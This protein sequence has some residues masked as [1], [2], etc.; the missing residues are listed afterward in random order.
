MTGCEGKFNDGKN[1]KS[2]LR[3]R[4]KSKEMMEDYI[5]PYNKDMLASG[6]PLKTI[7]SGTKDAFNTDKKKR[8]RGQSKENP[9][10]RRKGL[11]SAK[12][13]NLRT[14][15]RSRSKSSR[16]RSK[17]GRKRVEISI[18]DFGNQNTNQSKPR[19]RSKSQARKVRTTAGRR[20]GRGG[21]KSRSK[22]RGK[23]TGPLTQV[24]I[25]DF[26]VTH[27]S[28]SPSKKS[29]RG[30]HNHTSFCEKT[31]FKKE[32]NSQKKKRLFGPGS[33]IVN[34]LLDADSRSKE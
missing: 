28:K 34:P 27:N 25:S 7:I 2:R 21:S 30:H 19:S 5:S 15:S 26:N 20:A 4:S 16:S 24:N 6:L 11:T 12:G 29:K 8:K 1:G 23:N 3:G 32:S 18:S 31:K 17:S 22:S 33:S 9:K 13:Y 10:R 14:A